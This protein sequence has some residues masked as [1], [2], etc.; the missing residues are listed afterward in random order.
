MINIIGQGDKETTYLMS[1]V[2]DD[3]PKTCNSIK[4]LI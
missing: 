2:N 3:I 4:F 1:Y